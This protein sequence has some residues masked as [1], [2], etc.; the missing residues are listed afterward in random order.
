MSPE[1]FIRKICH[2]LRAPIRGLTDIPEWIE[3][4][5]KANQ[6]KL[7]ASV[8][9]LLNMQKTQAQRL[10]LIVIGLSEIARLERKDADPRTD[11]NACE[12]ATGWP[13]SLRIDMDVEA[14]P[15][16]TEHAKLVIHHLVDNAFKHG[17][18][19][20]QS[21]TLTVSNVRDGIRIAVTD[22][23]P[24]IEAQYCEKVYEPLYTLV[25]RDLCESSGMGL[26]VVSKI[27]ELY[28]GSCSIRSNEQ[29]IGL[30]SDIIVPGG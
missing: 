28:H 30:V 7:P 9:D 27:A 20:Q 12:P 16:E 5:L 6:I 23:G 4:D 13:A 19:D 21:A 26:A 1:Q 17:L 24:G 25:P 14:L 8:F 18:A 2:D 29:G 22:H 15:L 10:N 3:E 11:L